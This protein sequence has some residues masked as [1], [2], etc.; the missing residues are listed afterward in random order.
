MSPR[1]SPLYDDAELQAAHDKGER[2]AHA[3]LRRS[4]PEIAQR[5]NRSD[6]PAVA[7][8]K[9]YLNAVISARVEWNHH[10]RQH[11]QDVDADTPMELPDE[12]TLFPEP[13]HG[14]NAEPES[15]STAEMVDGVRIIDLDDDD[16]AD[17]STAVQFIALADAARQREPHG[18]QRPMPP[19]GICPHARKH[20]LTNW[21][22]ARRVEHAR[23][24]GDP[25]AAKGTPNA[26][27]CDH[28]GFWHYGHT[29][30]RSAR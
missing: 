21:Q 30:R 14:P 18:Q 20:C 12:P 5:P 1:R 26:Y 29:K 10:D 15:A 13:T 23:T 2:A 6:S 17:V 28:C 4:Q 9:G 22:A 19:K 16:V 27:Y 25:H 7:F 24:E 11:R 8:A 3:R